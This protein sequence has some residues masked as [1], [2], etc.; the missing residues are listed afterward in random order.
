MLIRLFRYRESL[1]ETDARSLYDAELSR[2]DGSPD[3]ELSVYDAD[4]TRLI[5]LTLEHFADAGND[6]PRHATGMDVQPAR[7]GGVR[8]R[9]P[10]GGRFEL[11]SSAHHVLQFQD[12]PDQIEF[13]RLLVALLA[14]SAPP[15]W[16][17]DRPA[18]RRWLADR[19]QAGDSEWSGF[20]AVA[21][22]TWKKFPKRA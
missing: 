5:Q 2:S 17:H 18:L 21:R 8:V 22:D 7:E 3:L 14:S 6:P 15:A 13:A 16:T 9:E 12:A 4:S 10:T 11:A 1:Q 20:L 19:V